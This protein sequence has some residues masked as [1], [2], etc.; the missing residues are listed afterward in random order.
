MKK[1]LD[2]IWNITLVCPWDCEFC[3]T[4]A[5]HVSEKFGE[6]IAREHS[7]SSKKLV[8]QNLAINFK[9]KYPNIKP[10]I[11]DIALL[12]RQNN[13]L[14]LSLEEKLNTLKNLE[15]YN[16]SIDFAGGD[17]LSC[18]ENYLVIE[19]ASKIFGKENISITSTGYFVKKYGVENLAKIIGEYEFT[20]D[21]IHSK[22]PCTRP[23]GYN[24]SNIKI[25]EKFSELGVKTKA[26]L[27]LHSGNIEQNNISFIYKELNDR[28]IDE[29]LIMRTFPVGRGIKYLEKNSLN[30]EDIYKAINGFM[31]AEKTG[32][33]NIR[34]Q[35]ALKHLFSPK[36]DENPCDMMHESFGINFRGELLLSAW[37]NNEKGLPLSD[38]FVLG[39]ISDTSFYEISQ[40]KNFIELEKRMDENFGHCKI[41]SYMAS[42]KDRES[43]FK[44]SDPLYIQV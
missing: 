9:K 13:G 30:K 3:C 42:D 25:A 27:P 14:E 44:K 19:A 17:P 38:A 43:L 26:Q 6:I 8:D 10:T 11:F 31:V 28:K 7:L 5:V 29:L 40:T 36:I 20:Y 33:T 32:K 35:C 24:S 41:F 39:S 16:V 21:E 34:L 2:I 18:Y 37:A 23:K 12:D 15:G 1:K 22:N 4:D